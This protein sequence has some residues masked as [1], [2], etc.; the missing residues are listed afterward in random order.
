MSLRDPKRPCKEMNQ[1]SRPSSS[2]PS[3][4]TSQ[5]KGNKITQRVIQ[6]SQTIFIKIIFVYSN[7]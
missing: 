3:I 6:I 1:T 4:V 2:V 5:E 7:I